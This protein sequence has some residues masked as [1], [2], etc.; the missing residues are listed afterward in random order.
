MSKPVRRN[1]LIAGVGLTL[2]LIWCVHW[3]LQDPLVHIWLKSKSPYPPPRLSYSL[4]TGGAC[5][6]VSIPAPWAIPDMDYKWE[7][8]PLLLPSQA[9]RLQFRQLGTRLAVAATSSQEQYP[10]QE[11]YSQ[12]KYSFDPNRPNQL[13]PITDKEWN[14]AARL[15]VGQKSV[16]ELPGSEFAEYGNRLIFQSRRFRPSGDHFPDATQAALLSPNEKWLALQ[17]FDGRV[18]KGDGA[19]LGPEPIW[20]TFHLDAVNV[21]S[22]KKAFAIKAPFDG[23]TWSFESQTRWISTGQLIL[24][25]SERREKFLICDPSKI[26]N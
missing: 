5:Q 12:N 2:V 10:K 16:A 22:Q 14:G 26:R 21:Q 13:T 20:G 9:G 4:P 23:A 18:R 3:L 17:S 11:V 7:P 6:E 25:F 15:E 24:D 1:L 8:R 19:I